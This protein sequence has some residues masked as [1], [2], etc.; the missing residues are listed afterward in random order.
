MTA[1]YIYIGAF[2]FWLVVF[3]LSAF[4]VYFVVMFM[5]Y[6]FRTWRIYTH[7]YV[8]GRVVG[9]KI[10]PWKFVKATWLSLGEAGN[11]SYG[12]VYFPLLGPSHTRCSDDD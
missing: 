4:L 3:L 11:T 8:G 5:L 9:G 10:N 6:S 12:G 1:I 7:P 2:V